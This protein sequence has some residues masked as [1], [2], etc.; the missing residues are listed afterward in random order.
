PHRIPANQPAHPLRQLPAPSRPEPQAI[1]PEAARS[2]DRA[3]ASLANAVVQRVQR[4]RQILSEPEPEPI[5]FDSTGLAAL[6]KWQMLDIRGTGKLD[7]VA[8]ANGIQTLHIVAGPE[9]RC[10]ASWRT[11]VVV[12]G[13]R[14][15]FEGRVRTRGVVPLQKDVGTKGVGAGLRQSQRQARKHGLTGDNE[16]RQ[17]EYEFTVPG[18]SEEIALLCELRA[19]KGEVWFELTSL[20]LRKL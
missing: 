7:Q 15:A 9:G 6:R 1:G 8:D 16:W 12:P 2:F 11:R 10:T 3:A 17:A 5:H 19:E 18:E 20:K 13:G 4:A 14:Y